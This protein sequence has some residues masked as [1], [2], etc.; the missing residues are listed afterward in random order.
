MAVRMWGS[1]ALQFRQSTAASL[2]DFL[3]ARSA[4]FSRLAAPYRSRPA[5]CRTLPSVTARHTERAACAV[6]EVRLVQQRMIF[7][8]RRT[9]TVARAMKRHD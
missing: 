8:S 5:F 9:M 1:N 3:V 2:A 7:A 4:V 6:G